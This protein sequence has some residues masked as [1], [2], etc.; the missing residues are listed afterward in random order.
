MRAD[1]TLRDQQSHRQRLQM[2]APVEAIGERRE[3]T[4]RV[5]GERKR[6]V[7]PA[8]A[9]LGIGEHRVAPVELGQI[10][11]FASGRDRR[12]VTAIGLRHRA[13]DP[14]ATLRSMCSLSVR[15]GV[16]HPVSPAD[17]RG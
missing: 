10:P 16:A 6:M 13:V 1:S 7:T 9:G 11:A 2:K 12:L 3:V 17:S 5:L 15:P 8:L 4:D 14:G